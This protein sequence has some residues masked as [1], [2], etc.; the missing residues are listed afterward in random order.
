MADL[1]LKTYKFLRLHR[2][3]H[4]NDYIIYGRSPSDSHKVKVEVGEGNVEVKC[5]GKT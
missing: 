3:T 1:S 4:Y 2:G 5:C